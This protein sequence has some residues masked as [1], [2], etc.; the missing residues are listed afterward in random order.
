MHKTNII[1]G[2]LG[3]FHDYQMLILMFSPHSTSSIPMLLITLAQS[4][5]LTFNPDIR[6]Q[7]NIGS[8]EFEKLSEGET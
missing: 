5:G 8:K 1:Q 7:L 6:D 4:F 2:L 3:K